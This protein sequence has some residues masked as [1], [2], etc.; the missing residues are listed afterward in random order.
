M[1][2]QFLIYGLPHFEDEEFNNSLI[3]TIF[4]S[5]CL[6]NLLVKLLFS[7]VLMI[8]KMFLNVMEPLLLVLS[9][10]NTHSLDSTLF[11]N[12]LPLCYIP[13]FSPWPTS[14]SPSVLL[15]FFNIIKV[16]ALI[17]FSV[18]IITC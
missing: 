14:H 9:V 4:V 5:T 6:L 11:R 10:L 17:F 12:K 16:L 18:I 15:F 3:H 2:N 8:F 7:V 13:F 1:I